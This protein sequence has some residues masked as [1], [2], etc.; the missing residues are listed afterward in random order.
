MNEVVEIVDDDT[1]CHLLFDPGNFDDGKLT[2]GKSFIFESKYGYEESGVS[3]TLCANDV[4]RVHTI[5]RAKATADSDT[6]NKLIGYC[7]SAWA[8]AGALRALSHAKGMV[9][10]EHRPETFDEHCVIA[11]ADEKGV[12]V[13]K[14]PKSLRNDLRDEIITAFEANSVLAQAPLAN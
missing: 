3:L 12:R 4:E 5:G 11:L 13:P 9:L 1:I 8:K 6:K 14:L 7:G 2:L 10:V